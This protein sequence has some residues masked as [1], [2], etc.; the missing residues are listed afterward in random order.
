MSTAMKIKV[1]IYDVLVSKHETELPKT[2]PNCHESLVKV[3]I[4][5]ERLDHVAL[6]VL[7]GAGADPFA[8]ALRAPECRTLNSSVTG[9]S[10][11]LC[12]TNLVKGNEDTTARTAA[13]VIVAQL[14]ELLWPGGDADAEWDAETLDQA[15]NI[16]HEGGWGIVRQ[17]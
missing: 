12:G 15:A 11:R 9:Y 13:V 7:L 14:R 8:D 17:R 1:T 16:L 5:E 3:G 6:R 4:I 2:C 10:C